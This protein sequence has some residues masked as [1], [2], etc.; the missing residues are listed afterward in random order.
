[1]EQN[2]ENRKYKDSVFSDLF[3]SDQE[4][5][6][7]LRELYN[8]LYDESLMDDK[9][10]HLVRITNVLFAGIHNDS[11]FM[12]RNR[13]IILSEHQSTVN[14][15]MPLRDLLYIGT[16]YERYEDAEN[17]YKRKRIMIP[18]PDFFTFYNGIEPYPTEKILKLSDS[19]EN[20]TE[21]PNLELFVRV[22][23]INVDAGHELL[24]K[25]KVLREYSLFVDKVR[26]YKKEGASDSIERAIYEC[27]EK[28]ILR[29][30]LERKGREVRN[31]L[32]AEY[33]HDMEMK[34]YR[35][36][37]YEEAY[38][39]AYEKAKKE[40]SEKEKKLISEMINSYKELGLSVDDIKKKVMQIAGFSEEEALTYIRQ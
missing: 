13:R 6:K 5:R 22:I 39:K 29:N 30:Y 10:I 32:F 25:C 26:R 36:E 1:M 2:K 14:E 9:D 4:A 34:V 16:E 8:A 35:Q 38:E 28:D 31:M 3:Y 23:N 33:D 15:N 20:Q 7:N 40:N 19:Y 17:R 18:T 37:C 27:I 21:N 11:A 24:S 12:V